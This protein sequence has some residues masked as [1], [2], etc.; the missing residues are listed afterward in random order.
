MVRDIDS[1]ECGRVNRVIFEHAMSAK[2]FSKILN[3]LV[4]QRNKQAMYENVH[5]G[6]KPFGQALQPSPGIYLQ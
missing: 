2:K 3:R 5:T 4:R 6:K 1:K